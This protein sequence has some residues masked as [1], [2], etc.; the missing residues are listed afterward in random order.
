VALGD[1]IGNLHVRL[2]HYDLSIS[3]EDLNSGYRLGIDGE[4]SHALFG[5]ELLVSK[6]R[7]EWSWEVP[8]HP[9]AMG[10]QEPTGSFNKGTGRFNYCS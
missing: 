8:K 5:Y 6:Y 1:K 10:I 2:Q 3:K 9:G 4:T 7:A